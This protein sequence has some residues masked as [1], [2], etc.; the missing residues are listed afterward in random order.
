MKAPAKSSGS[1]PHAASTPAPSAAPDPGRKP[2]EHGGLDLFSLL[3]EHEH[4]QVSVYYDPSTGYRGIIAIHSTVLGPALG[5][6]RFWNYQSDRAAL[7]DAL[8]L[9]RGMTYKAA[10]QVEPRHGGDRKST[11]LNSSH[12]QISYAVFCLKK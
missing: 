8:R 3:A 6:T 4:E 11:R 7:I 12:S 2:G 5:G 1:S 9:A 10:A